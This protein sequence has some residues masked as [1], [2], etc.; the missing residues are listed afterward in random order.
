MTDDHAVT[1]D[2]VLRY[3]RWVAVVVLPFLGVASI[4]LYLFPTQTGRLFAWTIMPPLT[5]MLLASAYIGGIWFFLSVLMERRWHHVA[6][7]FPAVLVF[8]T[9]LGVATLV[10]WDRFHPGHISF[11]A[12]AVLYLVTPF[13]VAGVLLANSRRD[14]GEPERRDV[15]IPAAAR[16]ALA[17]IGAA[18]LVTGLTLFVF[19]S[20]LIPVWPWTLTPLTARVVGAVLTLPGLVD[21]C[22]L[23]DSRWSSFRV[24]FQAQ[25]VSL[26]FIGAALV[27]SRGDLDWARPATG[28][29]VGGIALTLAGYAAFYLY[30]ARAAKW[31]GRAEGHAVSG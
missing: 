4:L 2:A 16:V 8:A 18:A 1:D 7:G 28:W 15:V 6:R 5:A 29:F 22:L 11:I 20:S 23:I 10:H 31:R 25:L 27:I 17:L 14:G 26:V 13:L 21:L 12:W 30:C 19:P 3:T 24:L 9:L